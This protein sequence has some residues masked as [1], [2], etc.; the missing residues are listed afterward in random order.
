[1]I[2]NSL[3]ILILFNVLIFCASKREREREREKNSC[4]K[5]ICIFRSC[6]KCDIWKQYQ[7]TQWQIKYI[8][9]KNNQISRY[10]FFF[11]FLSE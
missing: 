3:S 6:Y 1:M 10:A 9:S 4:C 7:P 2:L 5:F 8:Q 11:Y